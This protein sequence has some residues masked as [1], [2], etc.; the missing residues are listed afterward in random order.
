MRQSCLILFLFFGVNF[1]ACDD[2]GVG[3]GGIGGGCG[4]HHDHKF[5][6][7]Y[8]L[9]YL[10]FFVLKFKAILV[11]GSIWAA[12]L[13]VGKVIAA[14]KFAESLKHEKHH[15]VYSYPHHHYEKSFDSP[16]YYSSP[17][18][19]S[20][21]SDHPSNRVYEFP[22]SGYSTYKNS[23]KTLPTN[24]KRS[25]S[26]RKKSTLENIKFFLSTIKRMNLSEYVFKEMNLKTKSCKRKFVCEA[27]FNVRQSIVAKYLF[28]LFIDEDYKKYQQKDKVTKIEDCAELNPDCSDIDSDSIENT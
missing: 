6:Y 28:N 10:A 22:S 13:L 12:V 25:S 4:H 2:R 1:G 27:D 15:A 5:Y 23:Y 11:V 26:E 9:H 17:S 24:M 3:V 18:K 19:D 14:F 8:H 20:Y 7:L 21:S 16:I